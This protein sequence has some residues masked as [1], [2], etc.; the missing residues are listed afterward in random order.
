[1]HLLIFFIEADKGFSLSVVH[2]R[3][4]AN[5]LADDLSRDRLTSFLSKVPTAEQL[6]T[7]LPPSLLRLLLDTRGT[8]WTGRGNSPVLQS[9]VSHQR[10]GFIR[11]L[12]IG[13]P[14]S[15]LNIM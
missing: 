12:S 13:S 1:M 5:D 11:Q 2:V 8:C 6:P 9:R 14:H 10:I 15:V 7:P 3:G 4:V